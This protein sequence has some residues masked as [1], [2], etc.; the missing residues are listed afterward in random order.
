[1]VRAAMPRASSSAAPRAARGSTFRIRAPATRRA[2]RRRRQGSRA[3]PTPTARRRSPGPRRPAATPSPS[4]AST[5]TASSTRTATTRPA[6]PLRRTPIRAATASRT[7]TTSRQS[8]PTSRSR[9]MWARSL[10]RRLTREESGFTLPE[11]LVGASLMIVVM[12]AIYGVLTAFQNSAARTSSQNDAQDQARAATDLLSWQLRN[13]RM[14]ANPTGGPLEQ[15]SSYALVFQTVTP[16]ATAGSNPTRVG[17]VRYCYDNSTPASARIWLQ[18]QTWT[19]AS[20]PAVPS[21]VVCPD[22]AWGNQRIV[23]DPLV[24]QYNGLTRPAWVTISFPSTSTDP[25]DIVGLRTDLFVDIDATRKPL[26]SRL[27]TGT[28]LRNANRRPVAGFN[29]TQ[30]GTHVTLDAS[31]AFDPEGQL[32]T[33]AW[34]ISGGTCTPGLGTNVTADCAGLGSGTTVNFTVTV[35]D[36][37]GLTSSS[38]QAVTTR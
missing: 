22:P 29:A 23:A 28:A 7:T 6:T 24:N 21:T 27:T 18:T 26:E 37:G 35:T 36:P 17:R 32:L 4:T 11:L 1:M 20:P 33:Y 30:V 10:F 14:P 34:S 2:G 5:G 19:T 25:A 16:S 38:T 9:A 13:L 8:A 31:P 3:S 15:A 12:G